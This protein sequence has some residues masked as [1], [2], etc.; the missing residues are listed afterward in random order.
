MNYNQLQLGLLAI[1]LSNVVKFLLNAFRELYLTVV[2]KYL[3]IYA[4]RFE[5]KNVDI[6]FEGESFEHLIAN[7]QA[8]AVISYT[9]LDNAYKYSPKNGRVEVFVQDGQSG[10]YFSVSSYGPR[11]LPGE[12]NKIFYPFYRGEIAKR[13]EEEGAG[14]GLYLTQV[15]A[16]EHLLTQIDFEQ[17]SKNVHGRGHWTKFSVHIPGKAV[18]VH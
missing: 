15:V 10:I 11:I 16:K 4:P 12:S 18:V 9:F 6:H 5:Q 1:H 8:V 14:Y 2:T 13:H 3:R 7:P 17:E